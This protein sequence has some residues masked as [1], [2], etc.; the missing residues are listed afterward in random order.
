MWLDY[1]G[2]KGKISF[3]MYLV[4]L[5][6]QMSSIIIFY[7]YDKKHATNRSKDQGWSNRK[8]L[9]MIEFQH[10]AYWV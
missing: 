5:H 7:M 3:K 8:G 9:K 6:F 4:I 10:W 2:Y 1:S